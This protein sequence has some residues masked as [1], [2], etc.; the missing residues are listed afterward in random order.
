MFRR[1]LLDYVLPFPPQIGDLY[2]DHWI[3][4]VALAKGDLGCITRPLYDYT[5]HGA[6]ISGYHTQPKGAWLRRVHWTL[7]HLTSEQG[8]QRAQF[9]Y[10]QFVLRAEAMA[11]VAILRCAPNLTQHKKN[12]LRRLAN[13]DSSPI[14]WVWLFWRGVKD[15]RRFSL[16]DGAEYELLLGV[17]WKRFSDLRARFGR[18]SIKPSPTQFDAE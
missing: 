10:N 12:A 16:T 4:S 7:K 6:N 15:W 8:R 3:G 13:L 5:R 1:G 11:T 9:I 2:H 14:T 17:V 18:Q